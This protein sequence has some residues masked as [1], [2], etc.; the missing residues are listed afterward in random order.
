[1]AEKSSHSKSTRITAA[2]QISFGDVFGRLTVSGPVR[3]VPEGNAQRSAFPC[4]CECGN[5]RVVAARSLV[6]GKSRSCGCL[7][8]EGI[9]NRRRKHGDAGTRLYNTWKAMIRRCSNA[10]DDNFPLY[11]GRGI[12]V[13]PEWL[14]YEAFRTWASASGQADDLTIDRINTDGPYSPENCRWV[15]WSIQVRNRRTNQFL[16]AFGE[17]KCLKD[18]V[19]DSRCILKSS[20]SI[21]ERAAKGIPPEEALTAPYVLGR[22]KGSKNLPKA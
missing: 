9:G 2:N 11:G 5:E 21:R 17:T 22:H 18:W 10:A 13:C 12:R 15:K 4:V 6:N 16:T 19:A 3:L 7:G 1:M 14:D 8:A 20:S